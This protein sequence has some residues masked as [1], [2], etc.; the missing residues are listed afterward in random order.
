MIIDNIVHLHI[1]VIYVQWW[2]AAHRVG[3][4][5]KLAVAVARLQ[6]NCVTYFF[7]VHYSIEYWVPKYQQ[8]I[9]AMLA[10]V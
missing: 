5:L 1:N 2:R 4:E 8:S 10:R 7:V 9:G 3:S 6:N